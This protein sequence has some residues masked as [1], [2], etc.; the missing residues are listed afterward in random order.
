MVGKNLPIVALILSLL[1]AAGVAVY[2]APPPSYP[3]TGGADA[4]VERVAVRPEVLLQ[5]L[6]DQ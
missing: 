3:P 6:Q 2:A 4:K 5:Y 1:L